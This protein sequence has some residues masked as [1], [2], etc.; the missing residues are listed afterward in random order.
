[1]SKEV[2]VKLAKRIRELRKKRGLSQEKLGE[3]ADLTLRHIQRLEGKS[4][5]AIEIDSL[6]GLSKAFDISLPSL[7]SFD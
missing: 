3:K 7:L 4:P 6:V 1:M 5:P 2:R